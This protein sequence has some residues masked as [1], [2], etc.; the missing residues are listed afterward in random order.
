MQVADDDGAGTAAPFRVLFVCTGNVCRSP[1]AALL[2]AAEAPD[3]A[4]VE[5]SSAGLYALVGQAMDPPTATAARE[6]GVEP[7][8]HRAQQFEPAMARAADLVLIAETVQRDEVM[9]Q[10]PTA[11]RRTFALKE[12]ARLVR[13]LEPGEARAVVARAADIRGI[14]GPLVAGTDDITDPFRAGLD[15][16]HSTAAEISEAVHTIVKMLDLPMPA[17]RGPRPGP[18]PHPPSAPPAAQRPRPRPAP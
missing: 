14:D 1:L 13:H 16:A 5:V 8:R 2:F 12:L 3:G 10:L 9:R 6:H 11:L 18:R 15:R 7:S 17:R 4:L